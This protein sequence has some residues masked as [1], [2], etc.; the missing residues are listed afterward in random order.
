[1]RGS[2]RVLTMEPECLVFDEVTS[3]LDPD[4]G[5]AVLRRIKAS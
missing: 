3:M 2:C 5:E 1:M 4:S